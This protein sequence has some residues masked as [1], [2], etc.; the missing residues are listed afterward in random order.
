MVGRKC[1]GIA[2]ACVRLGIASVPRTLVRIVPKT[3]F[4]PHLWPHSHLIFIL[5]LASVLTSALCL[6]DFG[7]ILKYIHMFM[8]V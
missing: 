5:A 8:C 3:Q 6:T 1:A 2:R 7:D 4:K